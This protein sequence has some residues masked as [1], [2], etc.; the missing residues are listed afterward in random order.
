MRTRCPYVSGMKAIHEKWQDVVYA[1]EKAG[2]VKDT[3]RKWKERDNIPGARHIA[4]IDH[5]EGRL[6]ISDF[7]KET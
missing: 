3:Y 4:L 5:S 2:I 6:S 1:A 7:R